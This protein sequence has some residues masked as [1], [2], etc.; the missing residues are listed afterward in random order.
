M[1]YFVSQAAPSYCLCIHKMN[2]YSFMFLY[3]RFMLKES[4]GDKLFFYS[5]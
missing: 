2:D 5:I 4:R 3:Y 1:V